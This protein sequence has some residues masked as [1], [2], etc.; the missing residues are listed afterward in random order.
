MEG[1]ICSLC[2]C[3][4]GAG[5]G[6]C[7]HAE[8]GMEPEQSEGMLGSSVSV[9][10]PIWPYGPPLPPLSLPDPKEAPLIGCL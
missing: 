4:D 5:W 1:G 7:E 2:G 10:C 3:Q 9:C 8:A 6:Y